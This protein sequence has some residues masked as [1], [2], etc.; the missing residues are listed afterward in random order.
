MVVVFA[1]VGPVQAQDAKIGY[2]D[3]RPSKIPEFL[4]G[5]ASYFPVDTFEK[6]TLSNNIADHGLD[7]VVDEMDAIVNDMKSRGIDRIMIAASSADT[8]PFIEGSA[9][10]L[11]G[12]HSDIRHPNVIFAAGLQGTA[13]V[14]NGQNWYRAGQD[15]VTDKVLGAPI[16]LPEVRGVSPRPQFILATDNSPG[17]DQAN[18]PFTARAVAAG[19]EVVTVDLGWNETTNTFDS[20]SSLGPAIASATP[21][22]KVGLSFSAAPSNDDTQPC[23]RWVSMSQQGLADPNVFDPA[24]GNVQYVGLNYAPFFGDF[25][26]PGSVP[27]DVNYG[28]GPTSVLFD[29]P[30]GV[31]EILVALGYPNDSKAAF[32]YDDRQFGGIGRVDAASFAWLA[33]GG[34]RNLDQR[35]LLDDNRQL[36]EFY[37]NDLVQPAGATWDEGQFENPRENPRWTEIKRES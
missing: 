15:F 2:I 19:Y 37:V 1:F 4:D 10:S 26:N 24:N 27:V 34:E 3:W 22:S 5:V 12:V 20:F 33:T 32:S 16:L 21:G 23:V 13:S 36:V 14:D 28:V 9:G 29:D 6:V 7:A 30:A 35:H 18:T 31:N 11:G 25:D 17:V 8:G